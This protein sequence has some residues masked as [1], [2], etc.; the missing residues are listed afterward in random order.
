MPN[1]LHLIWQI[2]LG[3]KRQNVQRDFLKFTAQQIRFDMQINHIEWLK[4]FAVNAKDRKYLPA[5][6][7][8]KTLPC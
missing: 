5:F 2:Q 1:H 4:E 8:G 3:H 7:F 6:V